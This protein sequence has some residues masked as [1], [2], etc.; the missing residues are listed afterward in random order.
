MSLKKRIMAVLLMWTILIPFS[1]FLGYVNDNRIDSNHLIGML[2]A[3]FVIGFWFVPLSYRNGKR[4]G[5][6][7]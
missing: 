2:I 7:D 4:K 6:N 1:I 3:G 5:K